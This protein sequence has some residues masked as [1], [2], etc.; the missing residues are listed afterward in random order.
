[1]LVLQ[2]N[3]LNTA[4]EGIEFHI[5]QVSVLQSNLLN[6]DTEGIE[7]PHCTGVGFTVNSP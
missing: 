1:M 7:C 5:T 6:T 2:S 4:T 3:L